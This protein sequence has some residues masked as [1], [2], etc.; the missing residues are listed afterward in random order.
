[1]TFAKR[2]NCSI[3]QVKGR[4]GQLRHG[5]H[6]RLDPKTNQIRL[7]R[8]VAGPVIVKLSIDCRGLAFLAVLD[9]DQLLIL[10]DKADL[11]KL[12]NFGSIAIR[13]RPKS[14]FHGTKITAHNLKEFVR[15][16]LR[17]DR[18]KGNVRNISSQASLDRFL[19]HLSRCTPVRYRSA[20]SPELERVLK[21]LP[22]LP[23]SV[24]TQLKVRHGTRAEEIERPLYALEERTQNLPDDMVKAVNIDKNGL[25][26]QGF[27]AGYE[28]VIFPAEYRGITVRVR[29]V[30]IGDPGFL[31]AEHVLT[32]AH[33]AALSQITGEINV[34]S[35]LDG[36]D[37]L[38]PGRDSFYEENLHY[39]ILR[40]HLVGEEERVGGLVGQAIAA[41]LRRSG[42]R[43]SLKHALARAA[44]R[45]RAMD[46]VSAAIAHLIA[47][48]GSS[49]TAMRDLLK[50]RRSSTNGLDKSSD[51]PMEA[52]PRIG[53]LAVVPAEHLDRE[54]AIDYQAEEIS[55]DVSRPEWDWSLQLFNRR[56]A[57][58]I[59]RGGA[60][61]P[62]A[63]I[64]LK[65]GRILINWEHPVRWQMDDRGFLKIALSWLLAAAT[66]CLL[67]LDFWRVWRPTSLHS[68]RNPSR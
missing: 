33:K 6:Y 60:S 64:D 66:G 41:V 8:R 42:A 5:T 19:W 1:M 25:K 67:A 39:K 17:A 36:A 27:I 37:A 53:G 58:V 14:S 55:L 51:W 31:G 44:L 49:G 10:A 12:D 59:K 38:N 47:M 63:E 65:R 54:A 7:L 22:V 26:A 29:G 68:R 20:V 34:L 30:G 4:I 48:G 2:V 3:R 15:R 43:S 9:F 24:L 13:E 23:S 40:Q 21:L 57:V 18:R 52:P 16:D 11:E 28:Q 50:A 56:F 45:R 46:D 62:L 32:G 35:G 61:G